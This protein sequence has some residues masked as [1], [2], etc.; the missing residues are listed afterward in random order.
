MYPQDEG[1]LCPKPQLFVHH[2]KEETYEVTAALNMGPCVCEDPPLFITRHPWPVPTP[3]RCP[4]LDTPL[5][6][7]IR[8]SGQRGGLGISIAGGK[9]SLPY[10]QQD[11]GIFISRVT[12]GGPSEKAGV[13]VGDRLLEVNGLSM[14]GATHQLAVS[15]L[16]NAG[17]SIRIKVLRDPLPTGE[18]AL[19]LTNNTAKSLIC[20]ED[21]TIR[22]CLSRR[23]EAVVCNGNGMIE[24]RKDASCPEIKKEPS[25]NAHSHLREKHTMQIPRI[26]LTHPSTSDEDVELLT[27]SP[28]REKPFAFDRQHIPDCF[29]SAFYLP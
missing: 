21:L 22:N 6:L 8:V 24:L 7:Q 18:E 9:G 17:S 29:D 11:E 28:S 12:R 15:S 5:K 25:S 13:H 20:Q 10:K 3:D 27:R 2:H 14:H 4:S 16:R 23:I 19:D 26:I 1:G